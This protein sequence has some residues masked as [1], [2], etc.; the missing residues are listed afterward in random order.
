MR[1]DNGPAQ[2]PPTSPAK[3]GLIPFAILIVAGGLLVLNWQRLPERWAVHWNAGGQPDQW[4]NKT[5]LAIFLPLAFG[6]LVCLILEVVAVA[7][8][9]STRSGQYAESHPEAA[10]VMSREAAQFLRLIG[11]SLAIIFSFV[12]VG[13]PLVQPKK[14][15]TIIAF[16][17]V[18]IFVTVIYGLRRTLAAA[19]SLRERGM[20]EGVE[21]WSGLTYGNPNDPRLFV[22][23]AFT[24]GYTL[25]FAHPWAW[26][27]VLLLLL[28]PLLVVVLVVR[29]VS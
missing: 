16:A 26:P 17:F 8:S 3:L 15:A 10:A 11:I 4:A 23:R 1:M 5:P 18:V 21:G 19:R 20:L 24:P 12:S 13:L 22:P 2:L 7:V 29:A 25:N 28:T 9:R 27:L 14:P 6:A